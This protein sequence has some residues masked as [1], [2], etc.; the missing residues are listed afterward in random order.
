M[1][2]QKRRMFTTF[3]KMVCE[4]NVEIMDRKNSVIYFDE[5]FFT[6]IE[7]LSIIIRELKQLVHKRKFCYLQT[8]TT[9][10]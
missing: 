7:T 5:N 4:R 6:Q 3:K 8:M 1:P 9:G 2:W 10:Q